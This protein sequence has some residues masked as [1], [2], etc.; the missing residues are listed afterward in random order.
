MRA[1]LCFMNY[2]IVA[3]SQVGRPRLGSPP[4]AELWRCRSSLANHWLRHALLVHHRTAWPIASCEFP[5][6]SR[7]PMQV[8]PA[9]QVLGPLPTLGAGTS[10]HARSFRLQ[11]LKWAGAFGGR[12]ARHRFGRCPCKGHPCICCI[13]L[14]PNTAEAC[15][16][17]LRLLFWPAG[18]L[19]KGCVVLGLW[20][21]IGA[22]PSLLVGWRSR[23][24]PCLAPVHATSHLC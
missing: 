14:H 3:L 2:P 15:S 5:P 20:A 10:A 17:P 4:S 13:A 18:G 19:G 23:G 8:L 22:Q 24:K 11:A 16:W 12:G 7:P 1:A 6:H 9:K 21:C